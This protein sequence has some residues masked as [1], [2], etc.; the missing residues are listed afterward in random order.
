MQF[1]IRPTGVSGR[2]QRFLGSKYDF[3][4]FKRSITGSD[5]PRSSM[6]GLGPGSGSASQAHARTRRRHG[7]FDLE[8][9]LKNSRQ[10]QNSICTGPAVSTLV[11]EKTASAEEEVQN[12]KRVLR[13][14]AS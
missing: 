6:S 7:W 4:P 2:M 10:H 9:P 14:G 11:L 3:D 8:T 5:A 13:F 1:Q 12:E